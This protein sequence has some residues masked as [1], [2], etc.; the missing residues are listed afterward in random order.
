MQELPD[1]QLWFEYRASRSKDSADVNLRNLLGSLY[2]YKDVKPAD[3]LA[4]TQD[5]LDAYMQGFVKFFLKKGDTGSYVSKRVD[6]VKSYLAWHSRKLVKPIFIPGA[7]DSPNAESQEIPGQQR[8][9]ELLMACDL[10]T[11]AIVGLEAFC[12]FRPQVLGR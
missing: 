9:A 8:M 4:M 1:V 5:Q 7:D 12:G 11:A 3:L 2:A 10:R 6:A